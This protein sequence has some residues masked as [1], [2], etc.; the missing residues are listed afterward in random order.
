ME[1]YTCLCEQGC[2]GYQSC[3]RH[4]QGCGEFSVDDGH[5]ASSRI[6]IARNI[7]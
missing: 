7:F 2:W 6:S 1:E 3:I 4:A 5:D